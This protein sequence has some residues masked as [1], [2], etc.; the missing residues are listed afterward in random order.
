M[1]SIMVIVLRLGIIH[2]DPSTWAV[3]TCALNHASVG[4]LRCIH[5]AGSRSLE[6]HPP[7]NCHKPLCALH[8]C[9][10]WL[11]S[12]EGLLAVIFLIWKN[13]FSWRETL[14][15]SKE[16]VISSFVW[17]QW[18][19]REKN[20]THKLCPIWAMCHACQLSVAREPRYG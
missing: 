6:P 15:R 8:S 20:T 11:S 16:G 7:L 2:F 18:G 10:S 1:K 12:V 4:T 13:S 5:P 3:F 19:V 9:S 14:I 17:G